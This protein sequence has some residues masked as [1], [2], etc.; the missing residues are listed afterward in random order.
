MTAFPPAPA[1]P[2][3]KP[4]TRIEPPSPNTTAPPLQS[5]VWT[6]R[7]GDDG[8]GV[9]RET[10][11]VTDQGLSAGIGAGLSRAVGTGREMDLVLISTPPTTL[12]RGWESR[13]AI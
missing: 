10:R 11:R 4:P 1:S 6:H 13:L 5:A 7:G 8:G 2:Y 9:H 12:G 3:S